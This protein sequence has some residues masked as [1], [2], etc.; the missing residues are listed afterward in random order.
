MDRVV[1]RNNTI[2]IPN[3]EE[4]MGREIEIQAKALSSV[5][6]TGTGEPAIRKC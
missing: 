5:N 6:G 4:I 1:G 2:I 3:Y